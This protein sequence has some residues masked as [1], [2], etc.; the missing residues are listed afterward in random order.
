MAFDFNWAQP[1]PTKLINANSRA[2]A[3]AM[4]GY[5]PAEADPS[6]YV[7]TPAIKAAEQ[8]QGYTPA[9]ANYSLPN[10]P[11]QQQEMQGGNRMPGYASD[12]LGKGW[13]YTQ[14]QE[15][16]AA[17]QQQVDSIKSRIQELE[18]QI[19]A[20]QAKLNNWQG[21]DDQIAAI[22]ARKINASDPTSIWR[23]KVGI[24][25]QRKQTEEAKKLAQAEKELNDARNM[26]MNKYKIENILGGVVPG[27]STTRDK[28]DLMVRNL[29]DAEELAKK[30]N[31]VEA[32][33]QIQARKNE[34][35]SFNPIDERMNALKSEFVRNQSMVGKQGGMKK[36]E[37]ANWINNIL[38]N[39]EYAAVYKYSPEFQ[40][41]LYQSIAKNTKNTPTNAPQ[42]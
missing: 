8:M 27:D 40:Q 42:F 33:E 25:E 10:T 30:Y 15:Q 1:I 22:E 23:W 5:V 4:Q 35:A 6:K 21:V 20:N 13:I 38:N 37:F 19:A 26:T 18:S 9:M 29:N 16:A 11:A 3:E 36:A 41:L 17:K 39:P 7:A 24:N 2:A 34:L 28:L 31:D 32:L 14:K 12:D